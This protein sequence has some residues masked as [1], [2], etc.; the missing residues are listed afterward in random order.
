VSR[1]DDL[2]HDLCPDGVEFGALGSVCSIFSGSAFASSHFN[3]RGEGLPLIRIRDV[4]S[5]VSG[6]FYS[7]PYDDRFIVN[8]G[9]ILIGMDGD[10]RP[11]RWHGGTAL[12][13]Q[14]VCRLQDFDATVVPDYLYYLAIRVLETIQGSIQA[15]TV[16]HLSSRQL[17]TTRITLPPLED[18]GSVH[19]AGGGAGGGAGGRAGGSHAP[20]RPLPPGSTPTLH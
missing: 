12:L 20:V 4:N 19:S 5:G 13:N 15:S 7:G 14:R 2:V 1:I 9:D 11:S 18:S 10:F 6:T 8:D 16:K 3:T 17:A